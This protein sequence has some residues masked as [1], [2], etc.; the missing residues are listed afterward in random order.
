MAPGSAVACADDLIIVSAGR[1]LK[2][3]TANAVV[4]LDLINLWSSKTG[5]NINPSKCLALL[6][7]PNRFISCNFEPGFALGDSGS[8]IKITEELNILSVTITSDLKWTVRATNMRQSLTKMIGVLNRFGNCL[9]TNI[10]CHIFN[11]FI[12]PNLNYC[13]PF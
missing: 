4:T 10:R 8:Y 5:F 9:N 3:T 2:D 7:R 12:K 6:I 13:L 11:A 1:S